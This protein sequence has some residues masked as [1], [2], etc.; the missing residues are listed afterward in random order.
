MVCA[1]RGGIGLWEV[2]E[3]VTMRGLGGILAQANGCI[4]NIYA[5]SER[6]SPVMQRAIQDI[7]CDRATF[8]R[9]A[10]MRANITECVDAAIDIQHQYLFVVVDFYDSSST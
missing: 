4:I 9:C 3:Q 7:S 6:E 1:E 5:G 10:L 2:Q 8:E